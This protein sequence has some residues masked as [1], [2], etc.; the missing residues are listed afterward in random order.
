MKVA[1]PLPLAMHTPGLLHT[2]YTASHTHLAAA[3][4]KAGRTLIGFQMVAQGH[5]TAGCCPPPSEVAD[6][7]PAIAGWRS[8]WAAHGALGHTESHF[9]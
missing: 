4:G 5:Q 7:M 3:G 2:Q 8:C 6:V 9:R 1:T